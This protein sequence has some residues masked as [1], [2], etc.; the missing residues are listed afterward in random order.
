MNHRFGI[1]ILPPS[2]FLFEFLGERP[3]SRRRFSRWK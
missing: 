3:L 2:Y 1:I